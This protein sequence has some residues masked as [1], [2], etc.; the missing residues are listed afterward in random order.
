MDIPNTVEEVLDTL[1]NLKEEVSRM[2]RNL[3]LCEGNPRVKLKEM[4][5][6]FEALQK[7]F[8]KLSHQQQQ[9]KRDEKSFL[10]LEKRHRKRDVKALQSDAFFCVPKK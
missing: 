7:Q 8:E 4:K 5:Q 9:S 10:G 3:D 6:R 1:N 2:R